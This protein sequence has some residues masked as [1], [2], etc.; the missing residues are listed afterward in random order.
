MRYNKDTMRYTT[1]DISKL[2]TILGIWAHPDDEAWNTAGV[3]AA[4]LR[5]KQRVACVT[6][7]RGEAGQTADESRWP[8]AQLATIRQQE[9]QAAMDVLGLQEHYWLDGCADGKL[10]DTPIEPQLRRLVQIIADVQPGTILTFGHD[11]LTGH[12][13]HQ[14]IHN[15]AKLAALRIASPAQILC[16]VQS[17]ECYERAGRDLDQQFDIYFNTD[18]PVTVGQDQAD[19]CF[20]LSP[21]LLDSK[22]RALRAQA[23]QMSA[24]FAE[25][26]NATLMRQLMGSECF[27]LDQSV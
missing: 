14:T 16:V 27:M 2:G 3:M 17:A 25:P 15:W 7:T 6:A 9:M 10:A 20:V 23:S 21:E 22:E 18:R 19:V 12:P 11:G 26:H 24:M 1:A 4:A 13:D 5:A 8:Q